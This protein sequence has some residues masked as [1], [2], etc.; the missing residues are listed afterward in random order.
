VHIR[1]GVLIA[2]V[3]GLAASLA[4]V[5]GPV[6]A[7]STHHVTGTVTYRERMALPPDSRV[8]VSL[9]DVGLAGAQAKLV[10]HTMVLSKHQVPIAFDIAYDPAAIVASHRYVVRASIIMDGAPR[11][12][13]EQEY[14]VITQGNPMTA[15]I[16]VVGV[17]P[18]AVSGTG[19]TLESHPW[20]VATIGTHSYA[21]AD[22]HSRPYVQFNAAEKT[23][24]GFAGCNRIVG[25]YERSG[26]T[27]H[28]GKVGMTMMACVGTEDD[29]AFLN[30]LESATSYA[31]H[32]DTLT[33]YAK[34]APVATFV[35]K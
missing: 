11:F 7:A 1:V 27:L 22:T 12:R 3:F 2:F 20:A 33:L 17:S 34:G 9:Q 31:I 15:D 21:S 26:D 13:S 18:P 29:R 10:A 30:A 14:P 35:P 8:W 19:S 4:L 25:G 28:I 23:I 6:A 32:G 5:A 24:S 16:L